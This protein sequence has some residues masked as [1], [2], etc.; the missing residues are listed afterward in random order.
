MFQWRF[1]FQ[2]LPILVSFLNFFLSAVCDPVLQNV[3]FD[4]VVVVVFQ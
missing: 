1:Q 3:Y 2:T 4:V